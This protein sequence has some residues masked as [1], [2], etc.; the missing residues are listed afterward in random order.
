MKQLSARLVTSILLAAPLSLL[1]AP[2]AADISTR[3]VGGI[4][5]DATQWPSIVSLKGKYANTHFCGGTLI[6]EQWVLTAAHCMFDQQGRAILSSQIT[7]TVGEYDLNSSPT[8]PATNIERI[9][10]H[11]DYDP[12][13]EI[14]DL[15]LLKLARKSTLDSI[16]MVNLRETVSLIENAAPATVIGW[17]STTAYD[18][19]KVVAPTYPNILR[20]VEVPLNTDQQCRASLGTNYTSEMLCAGFPDGGKDSCQGDSGGPLMVN[21]NYGWQQIG[22]VSWGVG[23]ASAGKPGVYTRLAVYS[24]WIGGVTNTLNTFNSTA[25]LDF[26]LTPVNDSDV[27]QITVDNNSNSSATFTYQFAGSEYFSF[28]SSA[29]LTIA[30]HGSCQIPVTYA[31]L[32]QGIHQATITISSSITGAAIQKVQLYGMPSIFNE[33]TSSSSGSLGFYIWLLIPVVFIRRYQA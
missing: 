11:P 16:S 25:N 7:A 21:S 23:C 30:A 31:P 8:T 32:E 2:A 24:D 12:I 10:V 19:G 27:K 29:C 22:I 5:S 15:A 20:E 4:K 6:A 33:I 18:T 17:G 13:G 3:I 28:D 1:A 9:V 26:L 14:N